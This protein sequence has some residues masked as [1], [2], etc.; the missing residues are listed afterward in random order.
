MVTASQKFIEREKVKQNEKT[1]EN[2]SK[3]R[4]IE[5]P[6]TINNEREIKNLPDKEL[7]TLV[8]RMLIDL[9]KKIDGHSDNFN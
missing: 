6:W 2:I 7:K 9:E 8:L 3:E 4:W 5:D 1:E